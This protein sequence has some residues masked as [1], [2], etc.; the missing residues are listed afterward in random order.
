LRARVL[1]RLVTMRCRSSSALHR[2]APEE[3]NPDQVPE[4]GAP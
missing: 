3:N 2:L 4:M 1:R